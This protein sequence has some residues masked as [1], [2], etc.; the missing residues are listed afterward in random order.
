M[1]KSQRLIGISEVLKM[2]A[3]GLNFSVAKYEI[4]SKNMFTP[5]IRSNLQASVPDSILACFGVKQMKNPV[6][7]IKIIT[8]SGH[9]MRI[10]KLSK[11]A[12][13]LGIS[14]KAEKKLDILRIEILSIKNAES[15]Q[16]R[17]TIRNKSLMPINTALPKYALRCSLPCKNSRS[18]SPIYKFNYHS[19]LIA[20]FYQGRRNI[21]FDKYVKLNELTCASL[22]LYFAEG[23]KIAP[24]FTNSKPRIINVV[25]DFLESICSV[26]RMDLSATINC[27]PN[28]VSK[29]KNLEKFWTSQTGIKNF[30]ETLHIGP[31]VKSP[32]GIL[33][34]NLGSKLIKELICNMFSLFL[35]IDRVDTLGICRGLLCG[36]GSPIK[37]NKYVITHHIAIDPKHVSFQEKFIQKIFRDKVLKIKKISD[38]KIVLY[39]D[40]TTNFEFLFLDPYKYNIRNRLKFAQQFLGLNSTKLF[41]NI[42]DHDII[43]GIDIVKY[44]LRPLLSFKNSNYIKLKQIS[45]KPNKKYEIRLTEKGRGQQE[46]LRDFVKNIYPYYKEDVADFNKSLRNFD[47]I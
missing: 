16:T 33:E 43:K 12:N 7:I 17:T 4:L 27:S 29:R 23:G 6:A 28:M 18:L 42:K 14:L 15:L 47:L 25:L 44:G 11:L 45:P 46:R 40:W 26:T 1:Q 39:N 36:D 24:S 37:Q 38:R 20:G 32:C 21:I 13:S 22:G 19:K 41:L 8:D 2:K 10:K 3:R 30:Y 34:L 35:K 31:N 5:H 9:T